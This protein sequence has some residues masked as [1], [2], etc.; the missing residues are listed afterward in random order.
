MA[1]HLE[2]PGGGYGVQKS[3]ESS[4]NCANM[5]DGDGYTQ[6]MGTARDRA[7]SGWV[8]QRGG[9]SVGLFSILT[10]PADVL[11]WRRNWLEVKLEAERLPP[12]DFSG[13]TDMERGA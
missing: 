9:P 8:P 5:G 4:G 1:G 12:G 2:L 7:A 3:M 13:C 10:H 11:S 6:K